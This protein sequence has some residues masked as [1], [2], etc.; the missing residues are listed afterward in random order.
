MQCTDESSADSS[1]NHV[2]YD[3]ATSECRKC[4][5]NTNTFAIPEKSGT[6]MYRAGCYTSPQT[7]AAKPNQVAVDGCGSIAA[8]SIGNGW[9][10]DGRCNLY[11]CTSACLMTGACKHVLWS[12][13]T[14]ECRV[15]ST[16]AATT[17]SDPGWYVYPHIKSPG[18]SGDPDRW[19]ANDADPLLLP[20]ADPQG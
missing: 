11:D 1:C 10:R 20:Y 6:T 3:H 16:S 17:K 2:E 7:C 4:E 19:F 8:S 18:C 12:P 9:C 14:N 5:S 15:C 13:A